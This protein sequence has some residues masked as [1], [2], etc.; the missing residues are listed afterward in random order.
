MCIDLHHAT[1]RICFGNTAQAQNVRPQ[2]FTNSPIRPNMSQEKCDS[3]KAHPDSWSVHEL[4]K[5]LEK[6]KIDY[7]GCSEKDELLQ[8]LH[9]VPEFEHC[10]SLQHPHSELHIHQE[11]VFDADKPK[12]EKEKVEEIKGKS[13]AI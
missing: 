6:H 5:E 10:K 9:S 7:K 11:E 4:K 1:Q 12:F 8:L 3:T 13:A 2:K